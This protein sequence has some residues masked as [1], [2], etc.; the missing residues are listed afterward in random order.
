MNGFVVIAIISWIVL[1]MAFYYPYHHREE[2]ANRTLWNA[3]VAMLMV[4]DESPIIER[5][6]RSL[7]NHVAK[8]IFLCDTGSTDDTLER[9]L[10]IAAERS[11]GADLVH[12]VLPGGFKHFEQ[13]RNAC[14]RA[15]AAQA[16]SDIEWVALPDADFEAGNG[17]E[18]SSIEVAPQR[19]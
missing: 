10:A 1:V 5:I 15:L 2:A 16:A 7:H 18:Y 19:F 12:W 6:V 14:R 4:K 17:Y 13:A 8:R 9:A 3:T 11:G